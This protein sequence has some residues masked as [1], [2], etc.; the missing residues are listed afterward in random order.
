MT[1]KYKYFTKE[2]LPSLEEVLDNRENRINFIKDLQN[3][4]PSKSIVCFKLN[5]P[6]EQKIND[7][8]SK[9]FEIGL[10]EIDDILNNEII[11]RVIKKDK[12]GPECFLVTNN[13]YLEVKKNMVD[14]EENSYFGRL[15]DIDV[16]YHGENITREMIGIEQRKCFLCDNDAKVCARSRKHSLDEMISWIEN[17]IDSY[18]ED[19]L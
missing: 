17:L 18:E 6:G 4:Y 16:I 10:G 7:A 11:Y 1:Q 19:L 15:Y 12:T 13:E 9:I 5:I 3:N 14:L 8:I 2:N